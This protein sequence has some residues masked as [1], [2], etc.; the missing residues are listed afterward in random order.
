MQ[1]SWKDLEKVITILDQFAKLRIYRICS[2]TSVCLKATTLLPLIELSWNVIFKNF[3]KL[4]RGK[5]SSFEICHQVWVFYKMR[6]CIYHN[7]ASVCIKVRNVS[8]KLWKKSRS[9]LYNFFLKSCR[10][11]NNVNDTAEGDKPQKEI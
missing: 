9:I 4:S 5:S 11:L 7:I 3:S 6:N 8:R 2:V 10:S 1:G